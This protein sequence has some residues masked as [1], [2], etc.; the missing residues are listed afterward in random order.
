MPSLRMIC[1]LTFSGVEF[2]PSA[3]LIVTLLLAAYRVFVC[4]FVLVGLSITNSKQN[5]SPAS[6]PEA[7]NPFITMMKLG[8]VQTFLM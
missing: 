5:L 1:C 4:F 8:A 7:F 3:I 2:P 6:Y